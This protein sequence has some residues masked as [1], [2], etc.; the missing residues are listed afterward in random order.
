MLLCVVIR[1]RSPCTLQYC[2]HIKYCN[3]YGLLATL[4]P[5]LSLPLR[6][7]IISVSK[8][9]SPSLPPYLINTHFQLN[10]L[11]YSS[12]MAVGY[13]ITR[14][15]VGDRFAIHVTTFERDM[16]RDQQS[17]IFCYDR[18]HKYVYTIIGLLEQSVG[19]KS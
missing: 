17:L 7:K 9:F 8:Y 15:A 12:A 1:T 19:D 5:P 10:T 16:S 2:A 13:D 3:K 11:R 6:K 18:D 14:N 4:P